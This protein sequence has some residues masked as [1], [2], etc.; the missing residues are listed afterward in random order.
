MATTCSA[1]RAVE[2]QELTWSVRAR[3][4]SADEFESPD[5]SSDLNALPVNG[6]R[7]FL[8]MSGRSGTSS[9]NVVWVS[10]QHPHDETATDRPIDGVVGTDTVA[11][12]LHS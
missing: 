7:S 2:P 3:Q 12:R 4:S 10:D 1:S 9:G 8:S 11:M 5:Q 6:Q